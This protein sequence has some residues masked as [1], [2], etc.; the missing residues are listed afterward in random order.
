MN[1]LVLTVVHD[2]EDTRIRHKQIN[3]LRDAGHNVTFAAPFSGYQRRRPDGFGSVD[4]P[5]ARGLHRL[6]A[7]RAA[8]RLL[9][10]H[11]AEY[12]VVLLHD[13]ELLL[14]TTGIRHPGLVWDVHEDTAAAVRMKAWLPRPTRAAAAALIRRLE[15]RAER[16]MT[17]LL[18]E[19]GYVGRFQHH[20]PVVRNSVVEP[21][22]LDVQVDNRVLYLGRITNA[23]GADEM[24]ELGRRLAPDLRIHLIGNAD[25][26]CAERVRAAHDAGHVHWH[27]FIPNDDA[28]ALLPGALAGISLLHDQPNYAHSRPTKLLE[29]MAYGLPVITTPNPASAELVDS[30]GCGVVVGFGDVDAAEAALRRL[31]AEPEERDRLA[32]AGRKAVTEHFS[33]EADAGL[34]VRTLES[35]AA[36]SGPAG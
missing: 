2:P 4:V 14:A 20:H 35:V 6:R 32:A 27:G 7:L 1:V 33:W 13:P 31:A 29:Y 15:R 8:R 3:A 19:E 5:R 34:F 17:L 10:R 11:A 26:E 23:R 18:A 28:L 36:G 9:R 30:H 25:P 16:R 12:D 22:E 21:A 24:V